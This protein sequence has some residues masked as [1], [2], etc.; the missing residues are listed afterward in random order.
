MFGIGGIQPFAPSAGE[1]QAVAPVPWLPDAPRGSAVWRS[2]A[3]VL[4]A[5]WAAATSGDT[6]SL[7]V[8]VSVPSASVGA[9]VHVMLPAATNPSAVCAWECGMAGLPPSYASHWVSF[10]EGGGHQEM[11]A[12]APPPIA[13]SESVGDGCTPLWKAGKPAGSVAGVQGVEW[14]P[15]R[16]GHT[17]FPALSVA[18][19]NGD[20]AV[21]AKAC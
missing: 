19:T 16:P 7:W 1:R 3:G 4:S 9:D 2:K 21:F 10:D 13:P 12:I 15:S 11:T 20:F 17:M 6:W 18:A 5:A 14:L 8:N